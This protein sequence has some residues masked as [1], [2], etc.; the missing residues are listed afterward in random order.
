MPS[1]RWPVVV[2]DLDGTLVDTIPLIVASFQHALGSVLGAELP[3]SRI[4]QWIG[5]P[6]IDAFVEVDPARAQDLFDAY[7]S[8]NLANS[9]RLI[10]PYAGIDDLLDHLAGLGV[11]TGVVTSKRRSS[12]DLALRLTGLDTRVT[13]LAALE[14]TAVHKPDPAPLHLAFE[15]LAAEPTDAVY[16]GDAVVDVQ[17]AEAAGAAAIAV[18]WGAGEP[19]VLAA[20][21]AHAVVADVAGL[22]RALTD[23]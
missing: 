5:R 2:F 18:S 21:G 19:A 6:L 15:V 9:E 20:A 10:R 13:V 7:I 17:A 11:R 23:P 14:D 12:A 3:E 1:A 22:Q 8:W 16:V 4:R